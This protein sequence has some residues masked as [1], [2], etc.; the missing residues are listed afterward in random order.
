MGGCWLLGRCHTWQCDQPAQHGQ[1]WSSRSAVPV[2]QQFQVSSSQ[3][4]SSSRSAVLSLPAVPS[5]PAVQVSCSQSSSS[6]RSA[7]LSLPAVLGQL[8]PVFQQFQ[9]SCSQSS[10]SSR[11]AVPLFQKICWP[12][13]YPSRAHVFNRLKIE[14]HANLPVWN[15]PKMS[16]LKEFNVK[17]FFIFLF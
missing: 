15:P 10:S 3:S 13:I 11:S 1:C 14:S 2:Y 4:S 17:E 9:V 7:V 12:V 5:L 16:E 8:F 6:S